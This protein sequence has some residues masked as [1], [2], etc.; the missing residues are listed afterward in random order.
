MSENDTPMKT[1]SDV[2]TEEELMLLLS[3]DPAVLKDVDTGSL[4][5]QS[6]RSK[7]MAQVDEQES[8]SR[9]DLLTIR[10]D[11]GDWEELSD[12]IRKK[13]LH[14][15]EQSGIETYLLKIDAGAKDAPHI[16]TTDEHCFVLEGDVSFGDLHLNA[17]DYHLALKG[18]RHDEA[19]SV[20]GALLYIQT[21]LEQPI[22]L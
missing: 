11:T 7:I 17:G 2:L 5:M 8:D 16:H 15:D 10:A 20:Q 9:H 19:Y 3:S 21:G 1:G 12:K 14:V 4:R 22:R 6:L 13:V 18:S